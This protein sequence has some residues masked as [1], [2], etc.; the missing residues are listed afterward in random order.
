MLYGRAAFIV[1]VTVYVSVLYTC[2]NLLLT[3]YVVTHA[4]IN[5]L[6]T[7]IRVVF[8]MFG[9]VPGTMLIPESH[10]YALGDAF[11]AR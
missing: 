2:I 8:V 7:I 11:L 1:I 9:A 10:Y 6:H 4:G 5:N 3:M